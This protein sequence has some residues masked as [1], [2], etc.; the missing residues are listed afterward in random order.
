MKK[1]I[2]AISILLTLLV[3]P[4]LAQDDG[5]TLVLVTYD[6]FAIS[7][8]VQ[9]R[10]EEETGIT[11]EILRLTDAGAMVNQAILSRNNPLG[12]VLYGV[13]NTFLSR[14]FNNDLFISY[15]SPMLEFVPDALQLE[16][17]DF[18]ATPV[19][20]GD[21]CLNYDIAYF[22][23]ND[24]PLPQSLRDLTDPIYNQ[25]L[26]VENPASS[27]PGLAFLLATIAEFGDGSEDDDSEYTY[28]DFWTEL[29]EN[30]VLVLDGWSE[31]Y[32]G[33]F[34]AVSEDGEYPLVVSYASSPPAEVLF[35]E[36]DLE[37][38]PTGAIVANGTCFRQVEYV[39]ILH[40]TGKEEAAQQLID[41]MLG[42]EFQEDLPLQMFVFPVRE[43]AELPE[44]FAEYAAIP[45][46]PAT[47]DYDTIDANREDWIQDW[48]ETV[49]R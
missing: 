11:L 6:S 23:E 1:R 41:F 46:N 22:A 43:D 24:L 34:S 32:F 38:A 29:V 3:I 16:E 21:V 18:R 42:L 33:A 36:E 28:L 17:D 27:S 12:D 9:E 44:V 49:L 40:G 31:A 37:E 13:D 2:F 30:D 26:V 7:E 15:Q 47:I 35:A 4:A 19:T 20:F 5:E 25:L 45:E 8:E 14:A 48:T 39:G 10:F